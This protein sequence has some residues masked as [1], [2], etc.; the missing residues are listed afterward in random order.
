[1]NPK[2]S[3]ESEFDCIAFKRRVQSEL[4]GE[5]KDLS[6]EEELAYFR[7]RVEAGPL[8]KLW[9]RIASRPARP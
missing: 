2:T 8:A 6:T 9:R 7:R 4:Y 5:T 3:D 1:M